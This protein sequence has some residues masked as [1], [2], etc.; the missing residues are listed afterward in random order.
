MDSVAAMATGV[1]ALP[2]GYSPIAE[3]A[4]AAFLESIDAFG[5]AAVDELA[6]PDSNRKAVKANVIKLHRQRRVEIKR[7]AEAYGRGSLTEDDRCL[8]RFTLEASLATLDGLYKD[9][10]RS[11]NILHEKG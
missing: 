1:A 11:V 4:N 7:I 6:R 5:V 9:F 2:K 8:L 3:Q 10:R